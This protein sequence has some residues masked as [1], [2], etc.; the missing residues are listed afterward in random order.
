MD[1]LEIKRESCQVQPQNAVPQIQSLSLINC[2]FEN[3]Y[4]KWLNET[5][6]TKFTWTLHKGST[7]SDGTGPNEGA[8]STQGYVYIETSYTS[9][10]TI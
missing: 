3:T 9:K 1:D 2:G 5:V 10:S 4:C 6:G 7:S 8:A